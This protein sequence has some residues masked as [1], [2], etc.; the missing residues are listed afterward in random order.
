MKTQ[1]KPT[2]RSLEL[3]VEKLVNDAERKIAGDPYAAPY[4]PRMGAEGL[5]KLVQRCV[6]DRLRLAADPL[7]DGLTEEE[8]AGIVADGPRL[9]IEVLRTRAA[10]AEGMA[11]RHAAEAS[12]SLHNLAGLHAREGR[13]LNDRRASLSPGRRIDNA[14]ASL[15]SVSMVSAS[16]L[17]GDQVK[18]GEKVRVPKWSGDQFGSARAKAVRLC[19]ELEAF[20]DECRVRDL[21]KAA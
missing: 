18:G 3:Y 12:K 13:K 17:D 11:R 19:V 9:A 14:L 2:M 1:D 20:V 15:S 5:R 6:N 21:G 7:D 10:V 16:A 4:M 8:K